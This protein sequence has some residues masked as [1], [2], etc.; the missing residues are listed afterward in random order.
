MAEKLILNK[1]TEEQLELFTR[2]K[3]E[4]SYKNGETICKQ[5]SF[6]SHIILLK[7]GRAKIVHES[8][9][10]NLLLEI[11][12]PGDFLQLQSLFDESTFRYSA[13]AIE[14]VVVWLIDKNIISKLIR[15]NSDFAVEIIKLINLNKL[16]IIDRFTC[17]TQKQAHGR[18]ADAMLYLS[19]KVYR[20]QTF[21][22]TLSRKDLA[23]FTAMSTET[24]VRILTEFKNDGLLKI[25]GKKFDLHSP[26]LLKRLSEVG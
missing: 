4:I 24:V 8:R 10:K 2:S 26:G 19:E 22:L 18:M 23:E 20:N 12:L 6:A 25:T 5:G 9:I 7:E 13:I 17:L 15:E 14:K 21:D 11:V 16:D 1:L 3:M